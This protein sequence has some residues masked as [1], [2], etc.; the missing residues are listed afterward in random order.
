[1]IPVIVGCQQNIAVRHQIRIERDRI[2]ARPARQIREPRIEVANRAGGKLD[3]ESG[4]ADEPDRDKVGGRREGINIGNDLLTN[5]RNQRVQWHPS[6]CLPL[7]PWCGQLPAAMQAEACSTHVV[8]SYRRLCIRRRSRS[9]VF[10]RLVFVVPRP[11]SSASSMASL[12]S[13]TQATASASSCPKPPDFVISGTS[14]QLAVHHHRT[15]D[16]GEHFA[17]DVEQPDA[18]RLADRQRRRAPGRH[19]AAQ[20]IAALHRRRDDDA[21]QAIQHPHP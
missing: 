8:D 11:S 14:A 15:G 2:G 16:A 17:D 3:D 21:R 1:M 4:L 13:Q 10:I 5:A 7:S 19:E 6:P 9:I 12:R 18:R 20:I